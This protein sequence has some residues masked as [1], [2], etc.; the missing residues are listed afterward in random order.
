M[1]GP[2]AFL[3]ER[4]VVPRRVHRDDVESQRIDAELADDGLR[5]DVIPEGLVHLPAVRTVHPAVHE[6]LVVR[7]PV[8]RHDAGRELGVEP[9][10]GLVR[11]LDDPILGPPAAE[12]VLAGRIAE[13]RPARDPA[14]EPHVDR[15]GHSAHFAVALL[16]WQDDA[17]DARPGGGPPLPLAP[18]P[19]PSGGPSHDPPSPAPWGPPEP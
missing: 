12:L 2:D 8:E 11:P 16:A 7:G 6:H 1:R 14:V 5:L 13:A 17:G 4:D 15:V 18:F 10:A 19:P 3:L 9:T